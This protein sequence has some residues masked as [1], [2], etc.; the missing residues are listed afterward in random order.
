MQIPVF[1]RSTFLASGLKRRTFVQLHAEF[2]SDF[3][4]LFFRFLDD[5]NTHL[6]GW[7]AVCL[8][9]SQR[10]RDN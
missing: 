7:K 9:A 8:D 4:G 5:H 3:R 1:S 10:R 6:L 2:Q